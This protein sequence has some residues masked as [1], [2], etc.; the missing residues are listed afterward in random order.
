MK[1][2]IFVESSCSEMERNM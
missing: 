1:L 2:R